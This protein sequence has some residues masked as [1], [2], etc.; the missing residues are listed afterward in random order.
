MAAT[1]P[2]TMITRAI[3]AG[4][5]AGVE[6]SEGAHAFFKGADFILTADATRKGFQWCLSDIDA[7]S[8]QYFPPAALPAALAALAAC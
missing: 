8:D 7:G 3:S 6:W 2:I 4:L 1:T 5:P